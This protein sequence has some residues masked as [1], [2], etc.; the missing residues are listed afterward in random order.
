MKSISINDIR[1]MI[2]SVFAHLENNGVDNVQVSQDFYWYV[3]GDD[4][5]KIDDKPQE[6]LMGQLYHDIQSLESIAKGD[7]PVSAN[8]YDWLAAL[9]RYL[10]TTT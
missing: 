9:F 10:G 2:E 8:A 7:M 6:L 1:L 3:A 5:Y 4:L